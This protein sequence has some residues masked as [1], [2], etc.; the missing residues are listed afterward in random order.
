[1]LTFPNPK[2][3]HLLA[4]LAGADYAH[5]RPHLDF[6]EMPLGTV[7]YEPGDAM[8]HVYF[9]TTSIVSMLNALEDGRTSEVM[10]I[11]NEGMVGVC[12]F[13]GGE[14]AS[15]RAIVENGGWGYRLKAQALRAETE[16]AGSL[17]QLLL[18][19]TQALIAQA[20]QTAVCNRHHSLEQ[21]LCRWLLRTL[22][23]SRGSELTMTQELIAVL[24][25]VRREGVTE[26]A[27]RLQKA[28]LI[29]YARG[30][31]TVL[32]RAGLEQRACECYAV[33]KHEYH[34]LMPLSLGVTERAD[35]IY[36]PRGAAA[37][38]RQHR[39]VAA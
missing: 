38:V 36:A 18:L 9:P 2:D 10:S 19:F 3:N 5:L 34:R 16:R 23:R 20:G 22:D 13:L 29:R 33:V 31:I 1:M 27:L 12:L 25:G 11:G 35:R 6:V 4:A 7:L 24:L 26:G 32:D 8:R 21:R 39:D 28:G 30:H 14:T 17:S 37:P 15:N